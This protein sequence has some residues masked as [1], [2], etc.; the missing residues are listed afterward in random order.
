[1]VEARA[2]GKVILS[3]EHAVV[4]GTAAVAAALGLYSTARI[5]HRPLSPGTEEFLVLEL[6]QLNVH[7]S[8]S[9]KMIEEILDPPSL[10]YPNPL[11]VKECSDSDMTRLGSFVVKQL[12]WGAPKGTVAAV[13]TFLFLYTSILGLQPITV[14]VTSDLPVGAGLGSSAAYCVCL[15]AALLDLAATF[16]SPTEAITTPKE[17]GSQ[18]LA[19]TGNWH[20]VDEK[21]LE[22]VNK[23]AF[24]GERIIHGRPSGIDNTVSSYGYVVRFK[25]GELMRLHSPM[26][27]RM[28]L[29]NT[30]V[31][32]NTKA[33]VAGVGERALRHPAAMAAIFKAIDGIAEE[34]VS[35]LLSPSNPGLDSDD[36][37]EHKDEARS[38]QQLPD[39]CLPKSDIASVVRT[40]EEAKLE[41]LVEMNQG[42]LQCIG[43]SHV[44]I[45]A[46]CQITA[47][48]KLQSKLTGA[49]GGGCV[50]TLLPKQMSSTYVEVVK[51]DLEGQGFSCFEAAIGG[52]GVQVRQELNPDGGDE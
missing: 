51:V 28:L 2:P 17:Q 7:V 8:W 4:H 23:W 25:Q 47:A 40:K 38:W 9:L 14:R 46:I 39:E 32:R 27:L 1:V 11:V 49:G 35:I 3:G 33:L 45:E 30:N 44:S 29:T 12:S 52:H 20:D 15:A 31:G 6:P 5:R 34:V 26:P 41:E 13:T 16:D 50:L 43:V 21:N 24:E 19:D 18:K 37:H 22:L 36:E 10:Q 42:L 48:F